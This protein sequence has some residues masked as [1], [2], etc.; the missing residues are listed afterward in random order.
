MSY[1]AVRSDL[2]LVY[3]TVVAKDQTDIFGHLNTRHYMAIYDDAEWGMLDRLGM[4]KHYRQ[5]HGVFDLAHHVR[6]DHEVLAGDEVSVHMR[7]LAKSA[8]NKR[9]HYMLVMVNSRTG[10]VASTLEGL[11][12]HT[13]LKTRRSSAFAPGPLQRIDDTIREHAALAWALPTSGCICADPK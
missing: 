3:S 4:D 13:D 11:C 2:P 10:V 6:Y 7:L 8:S 12:M 5:E 1:E 9:V